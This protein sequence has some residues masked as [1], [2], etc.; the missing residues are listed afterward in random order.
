MSWRRFVIESDYPQRQSCW[1]M[2]C[3][4][5][6]GKDANPARK[7]RF[8]GDAAE[9]TAPAVARIIDELQTMTLSRFHFRKASQSRLAT[10]ISRLLRIDL[11]QYLLLLRLFRTLNKRRTW[12]AH[13]G[14]MSVASLLLQF[15]ISF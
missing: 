10:M 4:G 5:D 1:Q 11:D 7:K 13:L 14:L 8:K 15:G 12:L 9:S 2:D 6:P 3:R